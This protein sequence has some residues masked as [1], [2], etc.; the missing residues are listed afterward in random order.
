MRTDSEKQQINRFLGSH[1]LGQLSDPGLMSQIGFLAGQKI[2]NHEDLKV[3]INKCDPAE[4]VNMMEALKPYLRFEPK[5]LDVYVAEIGM[6]AEANQLPV[7]TEDGK[8]RAFN[9]P[10]L[11][12]GGRMTHSPAVN[13]AP[14][15]SGE[16]FSR[17]NEVIRDEAMQ[18]VLKNSSDIAIGYA[19][20]RMD[21]LFG[22]ATGFYPVSSSV[23]LPDFELP[24][25]G[26][27][28]EDFTPAVIERERH[29]INP[30]TGK[31]DLE[32]ANQVI[33]ESI[34]K[35]H[36]CLVCGVCTR[37]EVFH[38]W[39]KQDC[40]HQCRAAGWR[41]DFTLNKEICSDCAS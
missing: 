22:P 11:T 37:E 28:G 17:I 15:T 30:T 25:I 34:A 41:Y 23:D 36:L 14:E 7:V 4:R 24:V 13:S 5:P 32:I 35:Q 38:G 2:R 20:S 19:G 39:D 33:R 6:D 1:G 9:V 31:T 8:L 40:V 16:V 21:L 3:W 12:E 18:E 26:K 27:A 10:E 29:E